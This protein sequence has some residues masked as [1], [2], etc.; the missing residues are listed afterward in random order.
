M[1]PAFWMLPASKTWP[2]ELDIMEHKGRLPHRALF[3]E[4]LGI[5]KETRKAGMLVA[6]D[7]A[8]KINHR[9]T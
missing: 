1:W 6:R 5:N 7:A 8:A 3:T 2:P 9:R 4:G